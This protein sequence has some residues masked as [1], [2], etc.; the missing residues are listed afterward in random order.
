[1]SIARYGFGVFGAIALLA[2]LVAAAAIWLMLTDPVTVADAIS[3]GDL[4]PLLR[5]LGL[6]LYEALKGLLG[7]L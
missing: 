3:S 7:Y 2:A 1:M 5:A 4:T 6:A